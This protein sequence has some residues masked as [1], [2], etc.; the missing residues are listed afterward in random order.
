[1]V[2]LEPS[3]ADRYPHELS[4]GAR[5]RIVLTG[6]LPSAGDPPTGCRVHTRCWWRREL[7]TRGVDTSACTEELP[8]LVDR[9]T[10]NPAACHFAA[11][12]AW[13]VAPRIWADWADSP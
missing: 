2:G 5:Q 4:G 1:M 9:G 3:H 7:E 6:E 10:G 13:T 11:L 8:A 12:D